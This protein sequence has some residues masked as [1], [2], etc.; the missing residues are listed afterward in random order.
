MTQFKPKTPLVYKIV[1]YGDDGWVQ[2]FKDDVLVHEGSRLSPHMVRD[3][4]E[5]EFFRYVNFDFIIEEVS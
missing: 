1:E 3:L 4:I 5:Q 2:I